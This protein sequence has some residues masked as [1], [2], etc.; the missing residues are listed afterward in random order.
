[1]VLRLFRLDVGNALCDF[2]GRI[3]SGFLNTKGELRRLHHPRS[4]DAKKPGLNRVKQDSRLLNRKGHGWLG[5]GAT[6]LP[7]LPLSASKPPSTPSPISSGHDTVVL[8]KKNTSRCDSEYAFL[9]TLVSSKYIKSFFRYFTILG[10]RTRM[11][12]TN[13][14]LYC[15]WKKQDAISNQKMKVIQITLRASV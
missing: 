9:Q 5:L 2:G 6:H 11:Q 4:P 1:M 3:T 10:S 13:P 8:E 15:N 12:A 7:K 14:M